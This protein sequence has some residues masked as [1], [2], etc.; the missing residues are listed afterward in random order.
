MAHCSTF[1]ILNSKGDNVN[2]VDDNYLVCIAEQF[3]T[4]TDWAAVD[5]ELHP[6]KEPFK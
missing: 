4:G 3:C 6:G 2:K 1:Y 5:W